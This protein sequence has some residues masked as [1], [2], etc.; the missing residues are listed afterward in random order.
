VF[1]VGYT[2]T[3]Y[4]GFNEAFYSY[5]YSVQQTHDGGYIL[6][7]EI[8]FEY[9]D[10]LSNGMVLVKTDA[11]G[12]TIWTKF[13][14]GT[15]ADNSESPKPTVLQTADNGYM[16]LGT[17]FLKIDQNGN[18]VWR[19]QISGTSFQQTNDGGYIIAANGYILKT[20][21]N[22]D[23]VWFSEYRGEV[24]YRFNSIQQTNDSG[25][26][27]VGGSVAHGIY[28][29]CLVRNNANGEK[30]WERSFFGSQMTKAGN[31]V[32]ETD[33]GGL[34]VAGYLPSTDQVGGA[35]LC[36]F[37]TDEYGDS[38]WTK[39]VD[40]YGYEQ[41]N[42]LQLTNDGGYV[43]T[44]QTTG[45]LGMSLY[46]MKTS[47]FGDILWIKKEYV[48]KSDYG[49]WDV[50]QTVDGGYIIVGTWRILN[51]GSGGFRRALL[52][53]TDENGNFE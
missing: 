6:S 14:P 28:N 48:G 51:S 15:N 46:L 34:I 20:D 10:S 18:E 47:A 21:M 11:P 49:G 12:D 35:S 1:K 2:F 29:V 5:G 53:K 3:N 16:L 37:K 4:F 23:T 25:Y 24:A 13:Y 40:G 50:Q 7:G 31:T 26:V 8:I 41:H 27:A 30:L 33:D 44:G 19:K 32:R 42:A 45:G 43:I 38:L 17:K 22:G 36:L 52:T 39:I 9:G